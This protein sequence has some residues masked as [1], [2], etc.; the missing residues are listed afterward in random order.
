MN[1]KINGW[2]KL[3]LN[4]R[5][6]YYFEHWNIC[7]LMKVCQILY[8][9]MIENGSLHEGTKSDLEWHTIYSRLIFIC[10]SQQHY[11]G[12]RWL[13]EFNKLLFVHFSANEADKRS[14]FIVK[15]NMW[16]DVQIK[17]L[18]NSWCTLGDPW[19]IGKKILSITDV[20]RL[21]LPGHNT[22]NSCKLTGTVIKSTV[23]L[24][25]KLINTFSIVICF[26]LVIKIS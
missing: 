19:L 9:W 12:Q 18:G 8:G 10:V 7:A 2:T 24:N 11:K 20:C 21:F 1:T 3:R 4:L 16:S 17:S 14:I 23:Y 25:T 5:K 15:S 26:V 13:T 6:R 22:H